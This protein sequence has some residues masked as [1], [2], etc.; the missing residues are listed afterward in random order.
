[1]RAPRSTCSTVVALVFSSSIALGAAASTAPAE[2]PLAAA[3][4]HLREK[5]RAAT[6]LD[7]ESDQV[8]AGAAPYLAHAEQALAG[9]KRWLALS[10]LALIW[11]NLEA[12]DYRAAI[13]GEQRSQMTSLEQE[14]ARLGP[15]L[16]EADTQASRPTFEGVPAAARAVGEAALAEVPVYYAASLDYGKNTAPEYGLVYLGAARAQ[17]ELAR[18][19]ARL[20]EPAP[21]GAPL[22]P[23]SV[24]AELDALESELLAAYTPPASIDSH[25]VFIRISGLVKQARELDAAGR[26]HGALYKLLDARMRLSRL[27]HPGRTLNVD[28]TERRARAV[29]TELAAKKVDSSLALLFLE[30]ARFSAADPDPAAKGGEVASAI[31]EDVV[32]LYAAAL[33]PAPERPPAAKP[34]ATVTLVRWPYT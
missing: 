6:P 27:E 17:L 25:S 34:E 9:G 23:R 8:R 31:L 2:D 30:T 5:L 21:V 19:A 1:M 11:S 3:I 32:P 22:A 4:A 18:L 20:T 14:F 12:I 24:A 10:R 28:E 16:S 26:Y 33:G 13:P 15:E 7:E 29:E